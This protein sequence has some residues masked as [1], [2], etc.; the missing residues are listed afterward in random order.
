MMDWTDR[1]C[2][3]FHRL[4]TRHTRLYTEMVTTGALLHGDAPR[5][6]RFD[7]LEHP[8]ALQ[9]GGSEPAE[10]AQAAR[11]GA[12]WGY[13]EINLNCGCPSERVQRGAFGA[14]L[15]REP[16]LVAD[17]VKAMVDAVD[18]PVT[19]KHRI[20]IDQDESYA[21]VRDFVGTVAEAGCR[22]FIV[23]ARNAWLQ[24]LSPKENREIPPLRH[25]LAQQLKQDFP[26]L[27]IVV[28]GGLKSNEA[29]A[30]QLAVLDGVMVGRE[31]YHN[32]W[33]LASWDSTFFNGP[34]PAQSRDAIEQAMTEYMER[35]AREH[36]S[37]W[38]S[39]ARH[40]LGLRN[41][42]AGS[43]RWRQVWSDHRLKDLPAREVGARAARGARLHARADQAALP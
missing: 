32:P 39:I 40:M 8:V 15:M 11:L 6:L 20:G 7:A 23:H 19:V 33:L 31:A 2:R 30:A 18:V 4:L 1:H 14:C 16:Q 29:I 3:Y 43:R 24:G 9:L 41:G 17:C 22:V 5:H 13:D 38:Q 34:D 26:A 28:N 10:L 12:E 21:F 37:S 36:G 35:E 27:C 25:E 42:L